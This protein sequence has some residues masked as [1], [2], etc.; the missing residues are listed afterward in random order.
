M[1]V[2]KRLLGWVNRAPTARIEALEKRLILESGLWDPL[3]YV[4]TYG[5][6]L[7]REEA[8]DHWYREGWRKGED[9][10]PRFTLAYYYPSVYGDENP[11]IAYLGKKVF[12]T[13]AGNV[14]RRPDD[15]ARAAAYLARRPSRRAKGVVYTCVTGGYDDLH[16]IAVPG[17][18]ADDWDYVCF[19]DDAG[20]VA[21]GR[22]GVWEVRPLAF[23]E[24][25]PTR[26][27]RWHKTHPH[28]LFPDCAE[29]L[30]VD[31]NV[32][33]LSPMVFD[34]AAR[35]NLPF[36]LPRHFSGQ[37]V[38]GEYR[39]VL[40]RG[41]DD[42]ARVTAELRLLEASGM[43]RNFGLG[44]N[45]VLYRRAH[46][47]EIVALD[48]E[49]WSLIRDYSKRDQLS[50]MWLFWKRGWRFEDHSFENT[51]YLPDDF[52]VFAH[53]GTIRCKY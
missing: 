49:W 40:A 34:L 36:L 15:A 10:S 31:A 39:N 25:D 48:E 11:I 17:H 18:V 28:V 46:E 50:L 2:L 44:E 32:N 3:W 43:P 35:R 52:L 12:F 4:R 27:N 20:L 14:F 21:E 23:S 53:K 22:V 30:Y 29:S 33:V 38:W 9:P 42:P 13:A 24:L 8:L 6:D 45:N 51:R 1:R 5:H 26:N 41:I 7:T 37:C 47:P 16:E 19:T